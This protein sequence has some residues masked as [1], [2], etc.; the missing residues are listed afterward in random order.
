M[1]A[2]GRGAMLAVQAGYDL[3][4][5]LNVI[6]KLEKRTGNKHG[7]GYPKDRTAV[8]KKVTNLN[9]PSDIFELRKKRFQKII[10]GK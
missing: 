8:I 10:Y 6:K 3:N 4:S 9:I 5:A 2:D 1:E 7:T